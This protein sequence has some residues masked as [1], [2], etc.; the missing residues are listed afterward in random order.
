MACKDLS[1]LIRFFFG[2]YQSSLGFIS[3]YEALSKVFKDLSGLMRTYQGFWGPFRGFEDLSTLIRGIEDLWEVLRAHQGLWGL[4]RISLKTTYQ[5]ACT[6]VSQCRRHGDITSTNTTTTT[7][8]VNQ[9]VS[10]PTIH[11]QLDREK[12]IDQPMWPRPQDNECNSL[13]AGWLW[14]QTVS[15]VKSCV[16]VMNCSCCSSC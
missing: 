10:H 15:N 3:I 5:L 8:G 13:D 11:V 6:T 12:T 9:S 2:T 16:L 4:T 7:A 1:G 14:M